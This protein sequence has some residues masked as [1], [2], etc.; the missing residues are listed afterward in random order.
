MGGRSSKAIPGA[1]TRRGPAKAKGLARSDH[2]GSVRTLRPLAWMSVVAWPTIVTR[3]PS[4]RRAGV[5]GS[6]GTVPGQGAGLPPRR[7]R[8]SCAI[9]R[10]VGGC[11][12]LKKQIPSK[13]SLGGPE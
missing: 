11:P 3:R 13:W 9:P 4:T 5:A 12:G 1:V 7:Q 8:R 6:T 2:T 10:S